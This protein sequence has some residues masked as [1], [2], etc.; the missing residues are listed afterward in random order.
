[1]QPF[2]RCV[3][4]EGTRF[5]DGTGQLT[6]YEPKGFQIEFTDNKVLSI[7]NIENWCISSE[8]GIDSNVIED[9]INVSCYGKNDESLLTISRI[10]GS[11]SNFY[12]LKNMGKFIASWA[13]NGKCTPSD[14]KTLF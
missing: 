2:L 4:L 6:S 7:H 9:K 8:V 1:M 3:G 13:E 11:Y 10:D 14:N 5:N 12:S